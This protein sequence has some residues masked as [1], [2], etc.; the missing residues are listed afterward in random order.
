MP[1]RTAHSIVGRI[2][3]MGKRPD[4]QELDEIAQEKAGFR[5]SERGF[6]AADLERALDPESNVAL[7]ANTGG[8]APEETVRMIEERRKRI[9]AGEER[10]AQRRSRVEEATGKLACGE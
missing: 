5:A 10:L 1:F 3:A 2:A 9:V 4:L 6:S 7:R 8:P